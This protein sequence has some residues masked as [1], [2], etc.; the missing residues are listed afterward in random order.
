MREL[1]QL[2]RQAEA[3]VDHGAVYEAVRI[4]RAL[5]V[6]DPTEPTARKH[7]G[8]LYEQLGDLEGALAEYKVA[9]KLDPDDH[10]SLQCSMGTVL[11]KLGRFPAA[12]EH[13]ESALRAD[14]D[15]LAATENL[16]LVYLKAGRYAKAAKQ[17]RRSVELQPT[18]ARSYLYLGE[19]LN[20]LDELDE[21]LAAL[22][23][24]VELQPDDPRAIYWMGVVYDGKGQPDLAEAMYRK[25]RELRGSGW[26]EFHGAE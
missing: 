24:S 14:P 8:E 22:V 16:G 6:L 7:L 3:L 10:S 9:E 12:E 19:A 11:G 4:Y 17:L 15:D 1:A 18:R 20:R 13:L 5:L 21:A 2:Y 26:A 25:A 23:K